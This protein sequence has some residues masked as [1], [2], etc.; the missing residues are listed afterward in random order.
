MISVTRKV[1]I[2]GG[3]S[4]PSSVTYYRNINQG[5][6]AR[7]GGSHSADII[8]WSGDYHHVEQAQLRGDWQ[9]ASR[10]VG[11]AAAALETAGAE[12]LAIACNTMHAVADDIPKY[13]SLPLVSLIDSTVDKLT[14]RSRVAMLGTSATAR[15]PAFSKGFA[16][17]GV[18]VVDLGL[19]VQE[20]LDRII[21]AELCRGHVVAESAAR[22]REI[23]ALAM[24][25][26]AEKVILACTELNLLVDSAPPSAVPWLDT[27]MVHVDAI[28][29][30]SLRSKE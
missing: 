21:Y 20:E 7:L 5:V 9:E 28:V 12:F 22:L 16:K 29:R 27:T 23:G 4:W 19:E 8:L 11:V 6:A 17:A 24:E 10:L 30:A 1:G 13:S 14:R 18:T 2:I 25:R 3:M 15:M 26:G